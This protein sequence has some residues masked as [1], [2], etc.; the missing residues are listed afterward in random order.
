MLSN[1]KNEF[2]K[3]GY[4]LISDEKLKEDVKSLKNKIW[5]ICNVIGKNEGFEFLNE[6]NF[7]KFFNH[8]INFRKNLYESLQKLKENYHISQ[9]QIV[10]SILYKL[11]LKAPTLRNVSLRIDLPNEEKYLQ[12]MHQ[13]VNS[14]ES[15]NCLNFWVPLQSVNKQVG[16]MV[17][18]EGSHKLGHISYRKVVRG[19]PAID[20]QKLKNFKKVFIK[21]DLGNLVVF[22]P[23]LVH[24]S[25]SVTKQIR[26]TS[27]FRYDDLSQ[28]TWLKNK[29]NPLKKYHEDIIDI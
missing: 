7:S 24:G 1:L 4:F 23:C 21:A 29:Y 18:F 10:E 26:F 2:K 19:Y 28:I 15:E 12:P 13:D 22:H 3:N 9:N 17:L 20:S 6:E 16:S 11:G 25:S 8:D 5:S 27:I 14:M